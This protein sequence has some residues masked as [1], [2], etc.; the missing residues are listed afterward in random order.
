[1]SPEKKE[2]ADQLSKFFQTWGNELAMVIVSLLLM[3]CG[4]WIVLQILED[5]PVT[6]SAI[7][8]PFWTMFRITIYNAFSW[9]MAFLYRLRISRNGSTD[10]A[11]PWFVWGV[12]MVCCSLLGF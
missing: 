5:P 12:F 3:A 11:E 7:T 8:E 1:M 10:Y 6:A 9:I 2:Q 4:Y